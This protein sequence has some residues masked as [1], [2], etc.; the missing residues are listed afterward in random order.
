MDLYHGTSRA[1]A[2]DILH[3]GIKFRSRPGLDFGAGFYMTED[4]QQAMRWAMRGSHEPTV[5]HFTIDKRRLSALAVKR[6]HGFSREWGDVI[7]DERVNLRDVLTSYD[8]VIGNMADGEMY[9]ALEDARDGVITKAEFVRLVSN[10]IGGQVVAKTQR[11]FD[12][13]K[14]NGRSDF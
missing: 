14:Y 2:D 12:A 13:L 9:S 11:A 7:Y 10:N 8:F 3:S 4:M 5:L 1:A 6:L